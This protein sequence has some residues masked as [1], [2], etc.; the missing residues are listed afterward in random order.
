M[1]F[2][3]NKSSGKV[4][5]I[6][7]RV[8]KLSKPNVIELKRIYR[9]LVKHGAWTKLDN[10]C[11]ALQWWDSVVLWLTDKEETLS[12]E[13]AKYLSQAL[14]RRR[15]GLEAQ[16]EKEKIAEYISMI[17]LLEK[18]SADVLKVPPIKAVLKKAQ[19]TN[20][21]LL[22]I[23]N[24]LTPKF[25]KLL[26]TLH[27]MFRHCPIEIEVVPYIRDGM[28]ELPRKFDHVQ[29][30]MYY[31]RNHAKSLVSMY[32]KEG[33]LMVALQEAFFLS[34]AMSYEGHGSFKIDYK[35]YT[36]NLALLMAD[37]TAWAR[38]PEAPK[39]LI[40]RAKTHKAK[41]TIKNNHTKTTKVVEITEGS[42]LNIEE[43][44]NDSHSDGS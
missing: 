24:R 42:S 5:P 13:K 36:E 26:D 38:L 14:N 16:T 2:G 4:R 12:G 11:A 27:A 17:G 19:A 6:K 25:S 41:I 44:D 43:Q 32:R 34:R 39:T 37:F 23:K 20:I 31:S 9:D 22:K 28:H 7:K 18:A 3:H 33:P 10:I 40:R 8:Q 35:R 29:E 21:K 15:A 30:K 1:A